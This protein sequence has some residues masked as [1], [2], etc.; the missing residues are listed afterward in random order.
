VTCQDVSANLE[1]YAIGA[2]DETTARALEAHL[3]TCPACELRAVELRQTAASLPMALAHLSGDRPPAYLKTRML[4][5]V[6]SDGPHP[7]PAPSRGSSALPA[8]GLSIPRPPF[9]RRWR[10]SALLAACLLVVLSIAWGVWQ[11]VALAHEQVLRAE[12]ANMVS[13]EQ[14]VLD[15]IDSSATTK[16]RLAP[17]QPGSAAYGKMYV[18]RDLPYVVVMAAK[19]APPGPGQAYA[20][21][22][23]N[24]QGTIRAGT[25]TVNGQGFGVLVYRADHN[26]PSYD[27]ATVVLQPEGAPASSGTPA[28]AWT[29]GP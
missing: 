28:I 25:L 16:V 3:H 15:V 8:P 14:I 24:K 6:A 11:S 29:A 4:E 17:V 5:A 10:Y 20:L 1:L 22:L 9:W 7:E 18:R 27:A 19:L 21:W 23:T 26:D 2:L 12:F 13:Q